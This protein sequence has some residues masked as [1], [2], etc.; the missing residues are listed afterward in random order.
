MSAFPTILVGELDEVS[1]RMVET[2]R[3]AGYNVLEAHEWTSA[4][5]F[6]KTHSRP[7][8]V[9]LTNLNRA[10]FDTAE[11]LKFRPDLHLLFISQSPGRGVANVL[12]PASVLSAVNQ[13]LPLPTKV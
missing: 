3:D 7:I 8:H 6:I 11:I 1:P 5:S 10:G 9:F 12:D 4:L 2:L 13:L